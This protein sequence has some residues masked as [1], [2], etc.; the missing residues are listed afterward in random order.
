MTPR[1][2]T[3]LTHDDCDCD[4]AVWM[5]DG[6]TFT[7]I[8]KP[9]DLP[10][11]ANPGEDPVFMQLELKALYYLGTY[12][13]PWYFGGFYLFRLWRRS[14]QHYSLAKMAFKSGK[15]KR[16]AGMLNPTA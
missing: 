1:D 3:I 8:R 4:F 2:M 14:R 6:M 13:H 10:A 5:P 7:C 11:C 12:G 15:R 9:N 16:V